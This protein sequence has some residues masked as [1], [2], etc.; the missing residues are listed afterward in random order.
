M[1]AGA[2][3]SPSPRV[4]HG[5]G[6][7][8]VIAP[9]DRAFHSNR[10]VFHPLHGTLGSAQRGPMVARGAAS[11][12][13]VRQRRSPSEAPPHDAR[14]DDLDP[15][16]G[17]PMAGSSER[18]RAMAVGLRTLRALVG[19]G[20]ARAVVRGAGARPRHGGLPRRRDHRARASRRVGC[21]KKGGLR[22]SGAHAEVRPRRSMRSSTRSETPSGSCY[23]PGRPTR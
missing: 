1:P 18:L 8:G 7:A 20:R 13:A 15:S 4:A 14:G 12:A 2:F 19:V 3:V 22:R 6:N 10:S 11:S 16:D 5:F 9:R 17:C 21:A 23:R